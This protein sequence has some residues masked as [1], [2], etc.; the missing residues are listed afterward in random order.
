MNQINVKTITALTSLVNQGKNAHVL[1]TI[2]NAINSEKAL[3]EWV[4]DYFSKD[5]FLAVLTAKDK[6]IQAVCKS[7]SYADLRMIINAFKKNAMLTKPQYE[8]LCK[9]L[10]IQTFKTNQKLVDLKTKAENAHAL[11]DSDKQ[12]SVT[13]KNESTIESTIKSTVNDDSFDCELFHSQI[14]GLTNIATLELIAQIVRERT[15]SLQLTENQPM[16]KAG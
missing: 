12:E 6:T 13:G 7:D 16:K 10:S 5:Y 4:T 9:L 1:L 8:K 11:K 3:P 14:K 2:A 15:I